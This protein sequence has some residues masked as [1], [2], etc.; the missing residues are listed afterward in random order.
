LFLS[1]AGD[2]SLGERL[3]Q[4]GRLGLDLL[5]RFGE[6]LISVVEYLE[7]EGVPHRDIKPDNIGIRPGPASDSPSRCL[8]SR[9]RAFL[10]PT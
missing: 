4:E 6:E 3:R 7:R 8:T 1:S 10:R 2:E 5:Q 9:W